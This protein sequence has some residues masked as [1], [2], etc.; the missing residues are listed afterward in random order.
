MKAE[1][2]HRA[3]QRRESRRDQGVGMMGVER[4]LNDAQVG[5]QLTGLTIRR[6]RRDRVTQR[7]GAGQLL[8]RGGQACINTDQR[9]TVG[10]VFAMRTLIG[11]TRGE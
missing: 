9:A 6:L 2:L 1:D 4:G 8:Q 10:L 11:R 5:Q 7:L 3:Q